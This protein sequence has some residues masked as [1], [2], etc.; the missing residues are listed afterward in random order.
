VSER[1]F[2]EVV[3]AQRSCRQFT[4]EDVPDDDLERIL[5][6]AVRAPSAENSQPWVFVV[7]REDE[8]RAA[9]SEIA[10]RLWYEAGRQH[11]EPRISEALL[12]EVEAAVDTGFGGAP[13]LVV[14]AADTSTGIGGSRG[15]LGSSIYPA[16]QNLLLAATALGYGANLTTLATFAADDVRAVVGLP[17]GIEPMAVVPLGM[18]ATDLRA[19]R[20]QA[21]SEKA[22]LDGYGRAFPSG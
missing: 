4:D 9:L 14:V 12:Q 11:A 17:P 13:V 8:R 2:W 19:A 10:R 5:G 6:A 22:H 3:H 1:S 15:A 7:V 18:P 20:R 21:V 16:V